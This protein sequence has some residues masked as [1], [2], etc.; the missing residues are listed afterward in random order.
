M[1]NVGDAPSAWWGCQSRTEPHA[2][3]LPAAAGTKQQTGLT[4]WWHL[5]AAAV[6]AAAQGQHCQ[7]ARLS[8]LQAPLASSICGSIRFSTF[9]FICSAAR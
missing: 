9:R 3:P 2:P 1:P 4:A 7:A 6:Q 5:A 8:P